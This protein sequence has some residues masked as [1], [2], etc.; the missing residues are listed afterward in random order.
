MTPYDLAEIV[1]G[2]YETNDGWYPPCTVQPGDRVIVSGDRA[3]LGGG[4]DVTGTVV[5]HV[6]GT[7]RLI[8]EYDPDRVLVKLDADCP[9]PLVAHRASLRFASCACDPEHW[10]DGIPD[11]WPE[12]PDDDGDWPESLGDDEPDL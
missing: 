2:E 6:P 4:P 7:A 1:A 12:D 3:W 10:Y 9:Y 11:D 8:G 5:E